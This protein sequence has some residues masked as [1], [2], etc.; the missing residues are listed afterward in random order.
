MLE[1]Q[2]LVVD[3]TKEEDALQIQ[4]TL[5]FILKVRFCLVVP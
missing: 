3:F 4:I 2:S 5:K 1:K